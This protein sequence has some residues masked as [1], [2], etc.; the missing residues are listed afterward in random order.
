MLT[1]TYTFSGGSTG[2]QGVLNYGVTPKLSEVFGGTNIFYLGSTF[3]IEEVVT[4]VSQIDDYTKLRAEDRWFSPKQYIGTYQR[5]NDVGVPQNEQHDQGLIRTTYHQMSHRSMWT[6]GANPVTPLQLGDGGRVRQCSLIL[7]P[8]VFVNP[9]NPTPIAGFAPVSEPDLL[10]YEN[11]NQAATIEDRDYSLFFAGLGLYFYDGMSGLRV[12]LKAS[13]I[14]AV[15]NSAPAWNSPV[16]K[17]GQATCDE[18][19]AAYILTINGGFPLDSTN[20][21]IVGGGVYSSLGICMSDGKSVCAARTFT[22]TNGE[23]RTYYIK[24]G[25]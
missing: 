9:P 17:L 20:P 15:Y 4:I 16:C 10:I 6:I 23:T 12:E 2:A 13:V 22:C 3:I 8:Y 1:R 7:E 19:F 25:G 24:V 18:Q 14:N 11:F 5:L 21:G